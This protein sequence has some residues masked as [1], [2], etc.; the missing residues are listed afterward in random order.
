MIKWY[1][2]LLNI[3]EVFCIC[4]IGVVLPPSPVLSLAYTAGGRVHMSVRVRV[5]V[6]GRVRVRFRV[7]A[8]N[9]LGS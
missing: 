1:F 4:V 6:M 3:F 5:R 7:R 9:R 8:R 2:G